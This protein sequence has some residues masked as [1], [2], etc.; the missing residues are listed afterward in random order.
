MR[1]LV[2][3]AL[4]VAALPAC[5]PRKQ[6]SAPAWTPP[7]ATAEPEEEEEEA[8][9]R[10]PPSPAPPV[11]TVPTSQPPV[12]EAGFVFGQTRKQAM[13]AC[14]T[15]A[16]WRRVGSNYA[17]TEPIEDPGFEG[18]PVV[19]FCDDRVCAVGIALT[20][21]TSDFRSWDAA[22]ANV[23]GVLVSRHGEP[24]TTDEQIPE[25]CKN[26]GFVACLDGGT[27]KRELSWKWDVH[28]VVLRMSK[29]QD[30]GPSAI[31]FVSMLK[32]R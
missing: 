28:V 26:D 27:A 10:P 4:M 6:S 14:T 21:A 7:R 19:S 25:A 31:R 12:G 16:V 20:P 24:T 29:K 17:C 22:F 23:R 3:C 30:G 1:L 9:A 13:A 2:F 32:S 15:R 18:S 11:E 5:R 8:E